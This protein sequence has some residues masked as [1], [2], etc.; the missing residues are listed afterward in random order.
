MFSTCRIWKCCGI[1]LLPC[2]AFNLQTVSMI[3]KRE[4]KDW[5]LWAGSHRRPGILGELAGPPL[6]SLALPWRSLFCFS[7]TSFTFS[8]LVCLQRQ[9]LPNIQVGAF[10]S[11]LHSIS[12][13]T[14]AYFQQFSTLTLLPSCPPSW[15]TALEVTRFSYPRKYLGEK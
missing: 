9:L 8:L 7:N 4:G 5:V 15:T 11:L 10:T 1:I 3:D 13:R 14:W 12:L 2:P 6:K